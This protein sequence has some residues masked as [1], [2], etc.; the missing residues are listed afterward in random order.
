MPVLVFTKDL[1]I[2]TFTQM[3]SLF[4]GVFLFG[5]LIHFIS[6]MTF[7]SIERAFWSRGTYFVAWLGT[8]IHELGHAFFCVIF[9]HRIVKI[10]LFKPDPITGTLGYVYHKWN[11]SNPWQVLGNFFIA[12]GPIILGCFCLFT[13]FY[14]LIPNSSMVWDSIQVKVSQINSNYSIWNYL[15]VSKASAFIMV[16]SIFTFNNLSSWRFWVFCYLSIC[17]AS[18]IRLSLQDIRGSLSGFGYLILPFLFINLLGLATG[19]GHER[20]FPFTASS[21]GI[22]HSLLILALLMTI[23]GFFIAYFISA[24]YVRIRHGYILNPFGFN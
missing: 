17:I 20:F 9:M 10:Q 19:L 7:K 4:A 16:R 24:I 12:N 8:P 6:H 22:V 14:F 23:I 2:A 18:N 15:E 1:F 3:T 5:F 13:I 11:R 21:L